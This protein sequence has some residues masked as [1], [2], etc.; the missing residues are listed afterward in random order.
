L[1]EAVSDID[2]VSTNIANVNTVGGNISDVNTVAG[3]NSNVTTV[4]GISGNVTTVAGISGNVTSVAGN[5]TNINTVAGNTANIN[6]VATNN[7]D[8]ST[9]SSISSDVSTVAGITSNIADVVSNEANINTVA[10]INSNVTT[11]ANNN[12]NVTTTATNIANINSVAGNSGNINAVAANETNINS[13]NSN[14][15][16]INTVA[17]NISNVNS[18]GGSIANVNTVA[19]NLASVNN[20][21]EVY[22]IADSAPI[23]SLHI[24]DLYFDTT[25]NELKVYKSSGW[26]AAG[27][28]VNGT[29]AR[30]HYDISGNPFSVTGVDDNGNTLAYDAGYVDVYV[31]GVRM[32]DADI[33]ITSG[34]TVT[35]TEALADGDEVDI[36][37]YGTF[38]VATLDASNLSS[39]TVPDARITG[40]YTGITNLTMSGDLAVDTNTLYVD[41]ANNRVGVGTVS[42]SKPLHVFNSGTSYVQISGNSRDLFLGQDATG[43]AVFSTDAVPMYFSTNS[44]ER[45]RIDSSGRVGIGTSSPSTK[46]DIAGN[47]A[48]TQTTQNI[49]F[50]QTNNAGTFSFKN[51]ADISRAFI[52]TNSTPMTLNVESSDYMNFGTNNTEAMRIDSS[53]NLLVGKTSADTTAVGVEARS[54]GLLVATRTSGQPIYANLRGDDGDIIGIAKDDVKIGSIETQGSALIIN[55]TSNNLQLLRDTTGSSRGINFGIDHFKPFDSNNAQIDLGTSSGRFRNL[56]LSGGAYIGGTGSANYLDDYEEGTRSTGSVSGITATTNTVDGVYTKIGRTVIETIKV[57][58]SGK[59]GGSGNPNITLSF[60][61]TTN[62]LTSSFQG[63]S[64]GLNTVVSAA[65]FGVYGT[66]NQVYANTSSGGY[67]SHSS[68]SDGTLVFTVIYES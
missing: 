36:V 19:S 23:T 52:S 6:T 60:T 46:L 45:M 2:T 17:T 14:S 10:G 57:V 25:A 37:A 59:S 33:T 51:R 50:N 61:P 34:D 63:G 8:I 40:A 68:W 29:S 11:V 22:R 39:G 1:N 21:G 56:Y 18:V 3:I 43:A 5:A 32:S 24:G 16:N 62:V 58:I 15:T 47:I 12:A 42:P 48:Q 41:S 38:S 4:A 7:S 65:Y 31:N 9:V 64:I 30:F 67:I 26:A 27:S 20:F 28:T 66:T 53:G 44:T 54:V 49:E 13:V 55:A 35:F